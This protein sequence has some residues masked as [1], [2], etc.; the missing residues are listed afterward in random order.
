MDNVPHNDEV[1]NPGIYERI[2]IL[3]L[4]MVI[5]VYA[6]GQNDLMDDSLQNKKELSAGF[7]FGA[8]VDAYFNYQFNRPSSGAN[9]IFVSSNRHNAPRINLAY[10]SVAYHSKNFRATLMPGAGTY[11]QANYAAEPR[12]WRYLVEAN[13]GVRIWAKK[14]IWLDAGILGSPYTPEGPVSR[15]AVMYTRSFGPEYSPYYITGAKL[16][17][18]IH[19]KW[20]GYFYLLNG[21]Q[22]IINPNG[23]L[24]LGT[25]VDFNPNPRNSFTYNTFFGDERSAENPNFRMRRF[26]DFYWQYNDLKKWRLILGAHVGAQD[27]I[28]S[29]G[30]KFSPHWWQAN[31]SAGYHLSQKWVL[32]GRLEYFNDPANIQIT[33]LTGSGAFNSYSIGYS[34]KYLPFP[35]VAIR[36]EGRTFFSGQQVF[37]KEGV[38]PV[39]GD[40][41]A[42]ANITLWW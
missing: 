35:K 40:Q 1:P 26:S 42:I 3:T 41:W 32:S 10:F 21:W 19:P 14:N 22:H 13:A 36:L 8:Y 5:S 31:F 23:K 28:N 24:A 18:P 17:V 29:S 9:E 33:P 39:S 11:M 2:A 30:K 25:Q 37:V 16:S 7:S 4:S 27:T 34:I 12:A 15:D 38:V 6:I 20:K